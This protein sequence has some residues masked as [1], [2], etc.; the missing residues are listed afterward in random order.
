MIL[1]YNLLRMFKIRRKQT[2]PNQV[3]TLQKHQDKRKNKSNS[4]FDAAHH[5]SNNSLRVIIKTIKIEVLDFLRRGKA[6]L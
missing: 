3:T 5:C 2:L 4:R 6:C 1:I